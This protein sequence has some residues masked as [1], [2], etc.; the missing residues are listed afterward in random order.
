MSD[1]GCRVLEG[2]ENG[3]YEKSLDVGTYRRFWERVNVGL[4]TEIR[5][6]ERIWRGAG[7]VSDWCLDFV[8]GGCGHVGVDLCGLAGIVS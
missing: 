8:Y 1:V 4:V 5:V 3:V 6:C 7:E 2:A